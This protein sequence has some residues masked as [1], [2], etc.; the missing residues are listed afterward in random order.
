[1]RTAVVVLTGGI[2][3]GK[4]EA[5]RAFASLGVPIVDADQIAHALTGPG[6]LAMPQI[7]SAF[8][9]DFLAPD[10][11]LDRDR[12]R[13]A[14]FHDPDLRRRLEHILHPLIQAEA[15]AQ[16]AASHAPYTIYAVP[17]WAEGAGRQRPDWV[18]RVVV[19]DVSTDTQRQRV[20]SRQPISPETLESILSLQAT[21]EARL[22]LADEVL[23]N[24]GSTEALQGL[25]ESAHG[26]WLR[27]CKAHGQ[28]DPASNQT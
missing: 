20:M 25:I 8:G 17:L 27:S 11:R 19:I 23:P 14:A 28:P 1:M 15:M 2:G 5:C 6:G 26:R 12:M 4:T 18:W 22:A 21:R 24:E 13:Q 16:L 3:S 7:R 10:G 9:P